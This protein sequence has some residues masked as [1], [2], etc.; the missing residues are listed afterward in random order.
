MFENIDVDQSVDSFLEH[1]RKQFLYSFP[2]NVDQSIP[3]SVKHIMDLYRSKGTPRA[4]EL[5]LKMAY[6]IESTLYNPGRHLIAPSDAT[7]VTPEYIELT[8][9]YDKDSE[10]SDYAGK[11]ITGSISGATA[12]VDS[13]LK[14]TAKGK[15]DYVMFL[16]GIKGT[17]QR[18]ELISHGTSTYSPKISGSLNSITLT[19]NGVGL[20]AGDELDVTSTKY[21]INGKILVTD[22][23]SGTGQATYTLVSGGF[24]YSLN[25]SIS[26]VAFSTTVLKANNF[27]NSNASFRAEYSGNNFF[28]L[29][30]VIQPAEVITH[31]GNTTFNAAGNTSTYVI[32]TNSSAS[33]ANSTTGL[34]NGEIGAFSN[35]EMTV[36]CTSGTFGNQIHYF[37]QSNT[38]AFEVGEKVSVNST[39]TGYLNAA[40]S[41]VLI[42]NAAANG[43][44]NSTT[45]RVSGERSGAVSNGMNTAIAQTGVKKL[46]IAATTTGSN[47]TAVANSYRTGTVVGGNTTAIGLMANSTDDFLAT[48]QAFIK[49]A[50]SNTHADVLSIMIGDEANT[51]SLIVGTLEH[52]ETKNVYTDFISSNNSANTDILDVVLDGSNSG[53]GIVNSVTVSTAGSGY[54]N[55]DA[56][57]FANGGITNGALPTTNAIGTVTT[58]GSGGITGVTLT[59][60]GNGYY[61]TP[62]ITITTSGGSSG[63][64]TPV[65]HFGYG[66]PKHGN[67]INTTSSGGYGNVIN[68][69]LKFN[70]DETLGSIKSFSTIDGGNNYVTKPFI[71]A[72]NRFV[73]KFNQRDANLIYD[74]FTSSNASSFDAGRVLFQRQPQQELIISI[75]SNTAAFLVGEGTVQAFNST[76]NNFGIVKTS[77]SSTITITDIKQRKVDGSVIDVSVTGHDVSYQTGNTFIGLKSN[78]YANVTGQT[79]TTSNRFVKG[80]IRSSNATSSCVKVEMFDTRY[81]FEANTTI[82]YEDYSSQANLVSWYYL[83]PSTVTQTTGV[84]LNEKAGLNADINVDST[85]STGLISAM[86]VTQ[87]GYGYEDGETVTMTGGDGSLIEGTVVANSHGMAKGFHKSNRGFLNEDK[88]I[89]DNDFYQEF[90]YEVRSGLPLDKYERTLKEVVHVAGSKLFGRFQQTVA[91]N[92]SMSI[93]NNTVSQA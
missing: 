59:N 63:A 36:F 41:T 68:D 2:K 84:K 38:I 18:N 56:L 86:E 80:K 51:G 25:T 17:F 89:H 11:E 65:M 37:H 74:T 83:T 6:G 91:A 57:V 7:W 48:D 14:T 24:G 78:A 28:A 30:E 26:N 76:V 22:T 21:G 58:N 12:I 49:G 75:S 62:T 45:Q 90:S 4:V 35:T 9:D 70:I 79:N 32:G 82:H 10:F 43:F 64:L 34:A 50:N 81:D 19:S 87:S 69:V 66:L 20:A 85:T 60:H 5:F 39:V 55:G 72:Q 47:A 3:F 92:V 33:A 52:S 40:N 93:A 13:C 8:F 29:E 77:N 54:A 31:D 88:Y 42:I 67:T 44:S 23:T 15:L 16:S 46:W 71:T 1:F 73:E 53:I 61:H 27:T